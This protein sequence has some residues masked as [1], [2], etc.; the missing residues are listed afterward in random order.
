MEKVQKLAAVAFWARCFLISLVN[1][2]DGSMDLQ[3]YSSLVA[4]FT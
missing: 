3:S 4:A 1:R 2:G